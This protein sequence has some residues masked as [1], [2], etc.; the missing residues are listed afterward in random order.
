MYHETIFAT[1]FGPFIWPS[2]SNFDTNV[3]R[4]YFLQRIVLNKWDGLSE[5]LIST[6]PTDCCS[7]VVCSHCGLWRPS[8][9]FIC[10]KLS[11][12]MSTKKFDTISIP[13]PQPTIKLSSPTIEFS[14]A[15]QSS[16]NSH[17][18]CYLLLTSHT[19]WVEYR[20]YCMFITHNY[21]TITCLWL[22]CKMEVATSVNNCNLFTSHCLAGAANSGDFLS[23]FR[24]RWPPS[25]LIK[26]WLLTTNS[27]AAVRSGKLQLNFAG[28]VIF[29][30]GPRGTHEQIFRCNESG[31]SDCVESRLVW[32]IECFLDIL[33]HRSRSRVTVEIYNEQTR[34]PHAGSK[35]LKI[36]L[37]ERSNSERFTSLR[38]PSNISCLPYAIL[39]QIM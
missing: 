17:A 2:S 12:V 28:T 30:S 8:I 20:N 4:D 14:Q 10:S 5:A 37:Q 29:V 34:Q 23:C 33:E 26:G 7:I 11:L 19:L 27:S 15:I 24:D 1:C 13:A 9:H 35:I 3:S 18:S 6:W 39:H 32:H 21:K 36:L 16:L 38:R 25:C 22:I 31:S